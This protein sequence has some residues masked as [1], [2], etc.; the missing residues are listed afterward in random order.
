MFF[1]RLRELLLVLSNDETAKSTKSMQN[2]RPIKVHHCFATVASD[3]TKR[4]HVFKIILADRSQFLFQSSD[5]R[6]MHSW[7]DIL[8]WNSA[9]FSAPALEPPCSSSRRFER[10]LLPTSI[11]RLN[12]KDQLTSLQTTLHRFEEDFNELNQLI[13]NSS[14]SHLSHHKKEIKER[15]AFYQFEI[16]RLVSFFVLLLNFIEIATNVGVMLQFILI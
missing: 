8:N 5:S 3:Y 12:S 16:R 13:N 2:T 11:T 15:L 7:I 1:V 4:P 10:P 14:K 9:K 6:E